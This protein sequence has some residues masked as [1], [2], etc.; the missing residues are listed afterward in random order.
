M[1]N[2]R[3]QPVVFSM[4]SS[5]A[6]RIPASVRELATMLGIAPGDRS[7]SFRQVMNLVLQQGATAA[8]RPPPPRPI[9]T[10]TETSDAKAPAVV[11]G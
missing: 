4:G 2:A 6:G 7:F 10:R 3:E 8:E 5:Q 11:C 9:E 1:R